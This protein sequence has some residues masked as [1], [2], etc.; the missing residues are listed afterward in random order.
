[1]EKRGNGTDRIN[2][3]TEGRDFLKMKVSFG[4]DLMLIMSG[5]TSD[6]VEQER[7]ISYHS[8]NLQYTCYK[9]VIRPDAST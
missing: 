3:R 7:N 6:L 1:M 4:A 2:K 5:L 9:L 8:L